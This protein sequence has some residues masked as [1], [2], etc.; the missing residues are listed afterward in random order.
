MNEKRK[1][2]SR[3]AHLD[4]LSAQLA[5]TPAGAA[6]PEPVLETMKRAGFAVEKPFAGS[7]SITAPRATFEQFF[8]V[9]LEGGALRDASGALCHEFPLH[10]LPEEVRQHVAAVVF[11]RTDF[12]PFG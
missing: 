12:G 8:G 3:L 4:S 7:F 5:L 6:E 10:M 1:E 2:V 11:T 9:T